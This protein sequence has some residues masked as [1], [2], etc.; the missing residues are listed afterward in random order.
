MQMSH[1]KL[2]ITKKTP[3]T[4]MDR[5]GNAFYDD[6]Q[7]LMDKLKTKNM[8]KA[9][10]TWMNVYHTWAKHKGGMLEIEKVEPKKLDKNLKHFFRELKKQD[11]QDYGPHSLCSM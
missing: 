1:A 8:T 5:F 9:P 7:M 11:E 2:E 6:I 4:S 3:G 10:A